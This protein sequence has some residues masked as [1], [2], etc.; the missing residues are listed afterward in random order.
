LAERRVRELRAIAVYCASSTGTDPAHA[1]AARA[2]GGLLARRGITLVYG[3]GNVGLM[4]AVADGALA[5]GGR[6]I[7]VI[8][9][10]MLE[11]ERGHRG[12]TEL[13]IVETMHQRKALMVD[14]ADGFIALPGGYGTLDELFE[15]VTWGQLGLHKKPVGLLDVG[16]FWRPLAG[17]LDSV[18]AAG[19]ILPRFRELIVSHAEAERLLELMAAHEPPATAGWVRR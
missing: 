8:P 5:E 15:T 18:V 14:L 9:R 2:L 4:G 7:G 10:A 12:V 6:V 3:G 16:G 17:F 1:A 19:F 13:K 11:A